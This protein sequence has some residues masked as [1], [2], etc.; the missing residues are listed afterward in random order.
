MAKRVTTSNFTAVVKD[1]NLVEA[2][3]DYQW[4]NR[5]TRPELVRLA[6]DE[7]VINHGIEVAP[8]DSAE[9]PA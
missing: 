1:E 4:A 6:L 3:T 8:E 2:L 5:L 7:F 9:A